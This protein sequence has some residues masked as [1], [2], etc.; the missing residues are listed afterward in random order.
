MTR[1]IMEEFRY[2]LI[3]SRGYNKRSAGDLVSRKSKLNDSVSDL[4]Y[5]SIESIKLELEKDFEGGKF[6]RSTL[7]LM[8][9]AEILFREFSNT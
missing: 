1:E 8:I 6:S 4:H 9:R 7:N 2:W 3:N 5:L